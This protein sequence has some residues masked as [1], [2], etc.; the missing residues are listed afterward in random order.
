MI[1]IE[2]LLSRNSSGLS[3]NRRWRKLP[4]YKTKKEGNKRCKQKLKQERRR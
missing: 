4:G 2:A 3:L 1:I